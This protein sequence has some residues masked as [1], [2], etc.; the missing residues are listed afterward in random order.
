MRN[1]KALPVFAVFAA[2]ALPGCAPQ[3]LTL[4]EMYGFCIM[5]PLYEDNQC[6]MM[7]VCGDFRQSLE[8]EFPSL[9][10]CL[11]ACRETARRQTMAQ[12]LRGCDSTIIR[13]SNLCSQYCRRAAAK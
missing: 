7:E 2:L 5:E 8:R 6:E 4:S 3:P 9:D 11:A 1:V 13:G 12:A 10:A